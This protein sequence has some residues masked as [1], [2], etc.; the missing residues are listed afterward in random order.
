MRVDYNSARF[1]SGL[2]D[3]DAVLNV[4]T[5]IYESNKKKSLF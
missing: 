4:H 1:K 3:Y 5:H 2:L